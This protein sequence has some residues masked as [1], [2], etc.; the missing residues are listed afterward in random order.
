M[1]LT[2]MFRDSLINSIDGI[3]R[4]VSAFAR[5]AD[6]WAV[7][8]S[9]TNSA[10]T[11]SLHLIGSMNHFIGS[12]LG[13]TGYVRDRVSEFSQRNVPRDVILSNI[14]EVREMINLTFSMLTDADLEKIFP[15]STFGEGR[16]TAYVLILLSSHASYHLGQMNYLRRTLDGVLHG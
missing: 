13:N 9:V 11:L 8:G 2:N 5:E 16:T 6:I 15:L 7:N 14:A 4:E 10:G 12:T 3:S 1:S